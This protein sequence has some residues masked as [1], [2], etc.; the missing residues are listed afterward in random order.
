MANVKPSS[1]PKSHADDDYRLLKD[2]EYLLTVQEDGCIINT[3]WVGYEDFTDFRQLTIENPGALFF[4]ISDLSQKVSLIVS[5]VRNGSLKKLTSIQTSKTKDTKKLLLNEGVYYIQ[6]EYKGAKFGGTYYNVGVMTDFFTQRNNEDDLFYD[7][8]LPEKYTVSL[9]APGNIIENDWVGFGDVIDARRIRTTSAGAYRFFISGISNKVKLTVYSV[10]F[11]RD[12]S[13]KL[14]KMTSI[15]ASANGKNGTKELLMEKG[16]YYITV[17]STGWKK[18][19]NTSYSVQADGTSYTKGN[20]T[21]DT[22]DAPGVITFE[23]GGSQDNFVKNEWVG[24]GDLIDWFRIDIT[25]PGY[26]NFSMTGIENQAR[27][28]F[29]TVSESGKV[30]KRASVTLNPTKT[31]SAML[32]DP[33]LLDRGT[34]YL[35]MEAVKGKKGLN[36][37]YSLSAVAGE[38]FTRADNGWNNDI[39]GAG[40]ISVSEGIPDD[41]VG[42]GDPVDYFYFVSGENTKKYTVSFQAETGMADLQVF[43][44]RGK[45]RK[46]LA[47]IGANESA[48]LDMEKLKIPANS[49]IFLEITS[50]DGGKGEKNTAYSLTVTP[51]VQALS[52]ANAASALSPEN[53][54]TRRHDLMQL[55]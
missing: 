40:K 24:V 53:E 1:N 28:T 41:W 34:Y 4:N 55:A 8:L 12:G 32:K 10:S 6:T 2:K 31:S 7:G 25:T 11:G 22:W 46:T 39:S 5:E 20:N 27:M 36:T 14:K 42:F 17:E 18:G 26:Y 47:K 13:E 52:A 30:K 15:T 51:S 29:C 45:S 9:S 23:I 54:L 37:D 44:F 16:D 33:L 49:E 48:E 21:D 43:T 35:T 3:E 19:W 50:A 38:L